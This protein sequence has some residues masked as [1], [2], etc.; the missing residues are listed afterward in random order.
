MRISAY[1]LNEVIDLVDNYFKL[2]TNQQLDPILIEDSFELIQ[3]KIDASLELVKLYYVFEEFVLMQNLLDRMLKFTEELIDN[4]EINTNLREKQTNNLRYFR[5]KSY[6]WLGVCLAGLREFRNSK[7][8]T[9]KCL[10]L[11]EKEMETYETN[12][13]KNAN[14]GILIYLK[15]LK[16]ECLIDACQAL[17]QFKKTFEQMSSFNCDILITNFKVEDDSFV[18]YEVKTL[19]DSSRQMINFAKNAYIISNKIIDP[20]LRVQSTF[21]LA[22]CLYEN[23]FYQ[24]AAY[25]FN[26]IF[27]ISITLLHEKPNSLAFYTDSS[28]D[29]HM[30]S[31]VYFV[32]SQLMVDYFED[33]SVVDFEIEE[34][35]EVCIEPLEILIAKLVKSF[36]IITK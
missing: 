23:H 27:S 21:N 33:K 35:T 24:S 20:N 13:D 16:V 3:V 8:A 14:N 19:L 11:I 25:Y 10:C 5:I 36:E 18:F 7:L 31:M 32:K 30:E 15:S 6:S 17:N 2:D 29:Y 34:K 26:Q 28:P 22:L 1:Y 4:V 12:I 9:K